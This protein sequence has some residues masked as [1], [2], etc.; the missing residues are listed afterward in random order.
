MSDFK[1]TVA[2]DFLKK[3]VVPTSKKEDLIDYA[4]TDFGTLRLALIQYLKTV[5]PL[6]Y[7]NF[8]E[9]DMGM[10]LIELV[11]YMGSVMSY[12]A[13]TIFP[14]L[15]TVTMFKNCYNL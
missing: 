4:A 3:V 12:K 7:Q 1:G 14:L 13:E 6:E 2:S 8:S 5:Y 15:E 11:A 10:M 9:S